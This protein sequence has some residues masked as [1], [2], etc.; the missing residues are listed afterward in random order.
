M[1]RHFD[2]E[3]KHLKQRLLHMGDLA[4]EMIGLSIKVMTERKE[5]IAE[6]VFQLED[7]VNHLEVEIEDEVLRLLSLRQPVARDL[8]L[9]TAILKINND[10]ERVADQACNISE[11]ALY[12]LKEPPLKPLIDIP[13]MAM[14]A[15]KMIKNSLAAFVNQDARLA[16]EV[17]GDDDEV[18]R[19]ND[20][21]FRELLTYM[22]EDHKSITRAVDLILVARNLE[23]IADHATNISEDVIFIVEGKNIKHH[24]QEENDAASASNK[25]SPN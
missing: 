1:E 22:M 2:E 13:H 5:S 7:K 8:R 3:L 4:Q 19:I 14:L 9:L 16:M 15:Q 18:D 17:C 23:R 6:E 25:P 20:Q 10:L 24:I 11:T 12:L 21:V